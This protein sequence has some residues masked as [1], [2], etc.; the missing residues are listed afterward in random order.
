M[1]LQIQINQGA[2]V[3]V[4]GQAREDLTIGSAATLIAVGGPFLAYQWSFVDR[5]IDILTSTQSTA[6]MVSP[7][8]SSTNT[9]S[10]DKAGT[11]LVQ[12]LVDSGSGLGATPADTARITF[13]AGPTLAS[14]PVE[15][16][17]R[18]MAYQETTEH[19][20]PDLVFPA[21]NTRGWAQ[22]RLRWQA[23][24]QR[25]YQ[26]K[27]WAWGRVGLTLGGATL[28]SSFNVAVSRTG[29]GQVTVT[30][31][32]PLPNSNY[33]VLA[34]A[35]GVAGTATVTSTSTSG[36]TI[37]R[38]DIGGSLVDAAFSFDVKASL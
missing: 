37:E 31:E 3:G 5:P 17:R 24:L 34:T 18:E 10:L 27:T 21:G 6:T 20:V 28:A 22:E 16:P 14:S 23:V 1:A 2:S 29:V 13:Y 38:G 8:S 4:A 35:H 33:A 30:F 12:L 36:F 25:M 32:S 11:Y 15:L 19:N 9:S 7:S 26:G